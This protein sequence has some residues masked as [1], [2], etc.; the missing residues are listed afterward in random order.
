[1]KQE[2][3]GFFPA[4]ARLDYQPK[5]QRAAAVGNIWNDTNPHVTSLPGTG[6]LSTPQAT[7]SL[8]SGFRLSENSYFPPL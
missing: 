6:G 8:I 7:I 3:N 5:H 4:V 2:N 1:M